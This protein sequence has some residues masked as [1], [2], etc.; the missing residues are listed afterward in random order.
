MGRETPLKVATYSQPSELV[1]RSGKA[2]VL[3]S[4]YIFTDIIMIV[5][6]M[7]CQILF[8]VYIFLPLTVV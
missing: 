1:E 4:Q 3:Y 2:I 5:V 8:F 6:K 7:R